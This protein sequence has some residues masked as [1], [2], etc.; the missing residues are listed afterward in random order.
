M[1]IATQLQALSAQV[2]ALSSESSSNAPVLDAIAKL[3]ALIGDAGTLTGG[4]SILTAI[5][6]S[7][8]SVSG[9][10]PSTGT[11]SLSAASASDLVV[12]LSS[13]NTAA[14]VPSEVTVPAGSTSANFQV[15]TNSV[16]SPVMATLTATFDGV[17]QSAKLAIN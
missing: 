1:S 12:A 2:S 5:A 3:A 7:P 8:A 17:N 6:V 13:D 15:S 9:G 11:L 10:S 4:A 16:N 14:I